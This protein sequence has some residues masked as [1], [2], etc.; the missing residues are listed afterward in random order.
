MI[1]EISTLKERYS[2]VENIYNIYEHLKCLQF[3]TISNNAIINIFLYMCK[4]FSMTNT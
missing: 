4:Y 1:K 3:F 2:L